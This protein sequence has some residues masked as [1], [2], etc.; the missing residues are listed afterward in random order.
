MAVAGIVLVGYLLGSF[1]TP[2]I[3]GRLLQGIDLRAHGTG[4]VSASAVYNHVARW[5][6]LPVVAVDF[7]K[8]S[9]ATWLPLRLGL[10]LEVAL[11]AGAAAVVGHNWS[12]F[13]RLRGGRGVGAFMGM[14]LV[15][16]PWVVLWTFL[17]GVVLGRLL[18]ASSEATLAALVVIPVLTAWAGQPPELT[19][20]SLM[21]LAVILLKRLEANGRLLPPGPTRRRVL[22][23]RLLKDSDPSCTSAPKGGVGHG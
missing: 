14:F 8:G 19:V 11:L 10:S 6:V 17:V 2:Y 4:H 18:R 16:F 7:A 12:V 15:L 9:L 22:L 13:L 3:A 5:A 23:H 20:A 1:P 21:I